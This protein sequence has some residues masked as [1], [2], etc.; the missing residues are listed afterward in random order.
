MVQTAGGRSG[1]RNTTPRE[2]TCSSQKNNTPWTSRALSSPSELPAVALHN[3]HQQQQQQH[4]E[5]TRGHSEPLLPASTRSQHQPLQR[6]PTAHNMGVPPFHPTLKGASMA[7]RHR[8]GGE[9]NTEPDAAR[10]RRAPPHSSSCSDEAIACLATPR[11]TA[12]SDSPRTN[13]HPCSV[14]GPRFHHDKLMHPRCCT[15]AAHLL[16]PRTK[17]HMACSF[18]DSMA[19]LC[20]GTNPPSPRRI[21]ASLPR[22]GHGD[23][24]PDKRHG[25]GFRPSRGPRAC[26]SRHL[27]FMGHG[28]PPPTVRQTPTAHHTFPRRPAPSSRTPSKPSP[29]IRGNATLLHSGCG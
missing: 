19:S 24:Q 21:R 27:A 17:R 6:L 23:C 13:Q 18:D 20:G 25:M 9:E 16:G 10:R 22:I 1:L 8:W 2:G 12:P 14:R 3:C 26:T 7:P 5:A 28:V 11:K 29:P 4:E 15:M